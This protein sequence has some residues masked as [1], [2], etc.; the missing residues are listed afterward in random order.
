MLATTTN[1]RNYNE[2]NAKVKGGECIFPFTYKRKKHT[3]CFPTKRGAICA[4]SVS[5]YGTLKTYGYCHPKKSTAKKTLKRIKLKQ[6]K[7]KTSITKKNPSMSSKK[8]HRLNEEFISLLSELEDLMKMKGEPMRARAYSK[9]QESIMLILHDITD[10]S[11]L[12]G[13]PGIG[14]T[15]IKKFKEY[16]DTGTLRVLEKAKTNPVYLFAKIHGIGPKKAKA[17]VETNGITTMEELEAQKKDVLNAVQLK[18][19]KYFKDI[20]KRIPRKEID[21]YKKIFRKE[22]D[23]HK[24]KSGTFEIVGSYRRGAT[25]S[26]DIDLIIS[27]DGKD[28]KL[29]H[30]FIDALVAKGIIVDIL[31][32]GRVKSMVV[33]QLPGKPARRVDFMYAPPKEYSFAI[34]YFTGSKAFNVM[35]REQALV[36]GYSMNEHRFTN[37]KDKTPVDVAFPTEKSIFDFLHMA[38]KQ[39]NERKDGRAVVILKTPLLSE[40]AT[41]QVKAP[42]KNKTLKKKKTFTKK[43][44]IL[45]QTE[46]ISLLKRLTE[47]QLA[48]MIRMANDLYFNQQPILLD[49]EYDILKEYMEKHFPHNSVL[50]SIGAPIKKKKVKLPYFMPSMDK[51]KPDTK[52]LGKWMKKYKG[53]YVISAKADGVS[54]LLVTT[55]P[56]PELYTRGKGDVGTDISVLIPFLDIPDVPDCVVRGELIMLKSVFKKKYTK[57]YKNARAVTAGIINADFTMKNAAKYKDLNFVAYEV[58]KPSLKPSEQ[59]A[60]LEAHH[61]ITIKHVIRDQLTNESLSTLLVDWRKNYKY[62]NDG[63]VVSDDHIYPRTK[64]N[65][66]HAFAFKMVLSD[67]KAEAKVLEVIWTPS[68]DGFLKPKVRI[69]PVE[70]GDV[71]ITYATAFNADFVEKNKIGMGAIVEMIRSGDVI[72]HIQRVITPARK[73]QMP[74]PPYTWNETHVDIIVDNI[75]G[76]VEVQQKVV[77]RFFKHLDVEG[78]GAGNVKRLMNAGFDSIEKII[79]MK[80]EDFLKAE[81][82]KDKLATKVFTSIH[83]KLA[84]ASLVDIMAASNIFGRGMGRRRLQSI[85]DAYPQVVQGDMSD[86]EVKI[87]TLKGFGDKTARDFIIHLKAFLTFIKKVHLE[88]KLVVKNKK[89]NTNNPLFGK[90]IVMTGFRDKELAKEIIALTGKPL[91]TN[92]SKN[93]FVVL[94][95]AMDEDTT[96]A[97]DAREEEIPLMTPAVF[98]TKYLS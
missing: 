68:K 67:Q 7:H 79:N 96:K 80:K 31:S 1:N 46:G 54:G 3:K 13:V 4:T 84:S 42:T 53:P 88:N 91:S 15:I 82:F 33:A 87:K 50:K 98:R 8:M 57:T 21:A 81:G 93:T 14:K 27:N 16:V 64:K 37:L 5:K 36:L 61:F 95:K 65:P 70:V 35:M 10:P 60:F 51:I 49:N 97:E 25:T 34:L 71:T 19:L 52:F 24:G 48:A 18:G 28:K 62:Q 63:L 44:L 38:Y 76:N 2:Q 92:V 83:Q 58:I 89:M 73:A 86:V 40:E 43:R 77:S 90:S 26:G 55:H 66:K 75:E 56:E 17:L 78:L 30:T 69:E 39:P 22:F 45:F 85:L 47:K 72:P 32:K 12:V 20:Q 23:K 59:M 6:I 9:A 94:V 11:Q 74:P 41:I 29:F